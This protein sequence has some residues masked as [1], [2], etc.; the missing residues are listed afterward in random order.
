MHSWAYTNSASNI[1]AESRTENSMAT[2]KNSDFSIT[3][4]LLSTPRT[5]QDLIYSAE[6]QAGRPSG[7]TSNARP[8]IEQRRISLFD[9][10]RPTLPNPSF[11]K[12]IAPFIFTANSSSKLQHR[13]SILTMPQKDLRMPPV[14][15]ED[16]SDPR[17]MYRCTFPS[18][19]KYFTRRYNLQSHLKT[20]DGLKPYS[21]NVEKCTAEFS[22]KYDLRRHIQSLHSEDRPHTCSFCSLSFA[23]SDALKRHLVNESK[24]DNPMH[25]KVA[26]L[27]NTAYR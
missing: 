8:I 25:P 18:C 7:N 5:P 3:S 19:G 21:C 1:Y 14:N 15:D 11:R 27:Q 16:E 23:R 26:G 20:H 22:R 24:R 12:S 6:E 2:R 10:D 17:G 13:A 9:F 4:I